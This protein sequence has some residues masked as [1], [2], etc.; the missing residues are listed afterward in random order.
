MIS[1]VSNTGVE[2][3]ITRYTSGGYE[4]GP[5]DQ[6]QIGFVTGLTVKPYGSYISDSYNSSVRI[7]KK[8]L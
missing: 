2:T 1:H 3:D 5:A 6:G 7:I 4:D 8:K